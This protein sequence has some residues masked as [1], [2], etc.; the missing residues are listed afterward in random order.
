MANYN[1]VKYFLN[2]LNIANEQKRDLYDI[3]GHIFLLKCHVFVNLHILGIFLI[4][5]K[6]QFHKNCII[7]S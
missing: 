4:L 2:K 3:L 1:K 7:V 6:L 5:L